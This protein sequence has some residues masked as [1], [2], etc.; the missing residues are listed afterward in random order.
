MHGAPLAE[1]RGE[2]AQHVGEPRHGQRLGAV[3]LEAELAGLCHQNHRRPSR[4]A[5]CDGIARPG[6]TAASGAGRAIM[7]RRR[8]R[9]PGAGP[10]RQDAAVEQIEN[11]WSGVEALILIGFGVAEAV[12]HGPA[13]GAES[14]LIGLAIAGET[15]IAKLG[16]DPLLTGTSQ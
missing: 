16:E 5:A 14:I 9:A 4:T 15:I 2:V 6:A 7:A 12:S 1:H 8:L 11:A 3:D 13:E 10:R